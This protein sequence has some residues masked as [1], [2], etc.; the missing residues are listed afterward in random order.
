MKRASL[1]LVLALAFLPTSS[2]WAKGK[3]SNSSGKSAKKGVAPTMSPQQAEELSKCMQ[4]CQEPTM[5][6]M[7]GCKGNQSCTTKC[8]QRFTD[9]ASRTCGNLL[10]SGED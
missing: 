2:A 6:C 5:A 10:P 3:S 9:C 1:V 4:K 8:S 7:D